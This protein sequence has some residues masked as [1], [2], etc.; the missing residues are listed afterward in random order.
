MNR[1]ILMTFTFHYIGC[2]KYLGFTQ[3]FPNGILNFGSLCDCRQRITGIK[4]SNLIFLWESN[5]CSEQITS[6]AVFPHYSI[7]SI[8]KHTYW[9]VNEIFI[10]KGSSVNHSFSFFI[11]FPFLSYWWNSWKKQMCQRMNT[12]HII[13]K[14]E[15]TTTL[16][17]CK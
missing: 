8:K 3:Q 7:K 13:H 16:K 12:A 14:I 9:V 6:L 4:R 17:V 10:Q 5:S 11:F 15:K 2:K 1:T